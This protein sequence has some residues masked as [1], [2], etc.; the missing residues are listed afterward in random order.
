MDNKK[1]AMSGG[2]AYITSC[3]AKDYESLSGSAPNPRLKISRFQNERGYRSELFSA[4]SQVCEE[5]NHR[6]ERR[7]E[8]DAQSHLMKCE[9]VRST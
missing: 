6:A 5:I 4:C 2:M 1:T 8:G 9:A 7:S 3:L